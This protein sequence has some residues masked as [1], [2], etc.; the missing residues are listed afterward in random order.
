MTKKFHCLI[1]T[2]L[3]ILLSANCF[4]IPKRIIIVRHGDKLPQELSGQ[5]LSVK[6]HV[7]AIALAFYILKKYGEPDYLIA[8]DPSDKKE[9]N[10]SIRELETL[11]PLANMLQEKHPDFNVE[12]SHPYESSDYSNLAKE[13][14]EKEKYNNKTVLICWSH[15]KI[16]D[17][18][19]KLGIRNRPNDWD[20]NDFDSVYELYYDESG[21]MKEFNILHQ[22]YPISY[23]GSWEDL[24]KMA[25]QNRS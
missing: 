6:G 16:P 19:V 13:I 21:E 25:N 3:I 1:L 9:K 14:L 18:A 24:Y 4:A 8:T 15:G 12:I 22:Q 11:A 2:S 23:S 5:A 20:D 17:L 10:S 7:R